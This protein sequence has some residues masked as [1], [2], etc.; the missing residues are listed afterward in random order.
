MLVVN[1]GEALKLVAA[2]RGAKHSTVDDRGTGNR[3]IIMT[4]VSSAA[5]NESDWRGI[6]NIDNGLIDSS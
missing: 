5:S 4:R 6:E 1:S 3:A 2:V